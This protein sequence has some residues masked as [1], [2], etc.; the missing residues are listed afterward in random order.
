[1]ESSEHLSHALDSGPLCTFLQHSQMHWR[2]CWNLDGL[3]IN[4]RT[5]CAAHK[6]LSKDSTQVPHTQS[7]KSIYLWSCLTNIWIRTVSADSTWGVFG[8]RM[9]TSQSPRTC[10]ILLDILK[11]QKQNVGHPKSLTNL[12]VSMRI[13]STSGCPLRERSWAETILKWTFD[14]GPYW[15]L[16]LTTKKHKHKLIHGWMHTYDKL[17]DKV[18]QMCVHTNLVQH[19]GNNINC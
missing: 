14:T 19:S 9:E 2:P 15:F 7:E 3:I 8:K 6:E 13:I 1:M 17:Y 4:G 16:C 12:A 5:Q 10:S 11:P 18:W